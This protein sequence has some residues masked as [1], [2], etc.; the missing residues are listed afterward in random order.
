MVNEV[1][2][3]P[4]M[5]AASQFPRIWQQAGI[6]F[7][8]LLDILVAGALRTAGSVPAGEHAGG[9]LDALSDPG[10]SRLCTVDDQRFV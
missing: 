7:P 3:F 6:A 5:T 1:N 8:A 2:T 9:T 10:H 4:G